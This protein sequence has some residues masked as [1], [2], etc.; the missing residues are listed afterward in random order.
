MLSLLLAALVL[1]HGHDRGYPEPVS[2]QTNLHHL[3]HSAFPHQPCTAY[4]LLAMAEPPAG[5]GPDQHP[6]PPPLSGTDLA[7][8]LLEYCNKVTKDERDYNREIA[9]EERKHNNSMLQIVA[10]GLGNQLADTTNNLV[11]H[12]V[13]L[14]RKI[15]DAELRLDSVS[16]YHEQT[17][18]SLKA[19]L[20]ETLLKVEHDIK[21]I[22]ARRTSYC[23][24]CARNYDS[25]DALRNH[26]QDIHTA[27]IPLSC[28]YMRKQKSFLLIWVC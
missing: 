27:V 22:F 12:I 26:F 19:G 7:K 20:Q 13:T 6:S 17:M 15:A 3:P 11:K 10:K 5:S 8:L 23:E 2:S 25:M 16:S 1:L 14:T 4:Q 9:K 24:C 28:S 18:Y 21:T